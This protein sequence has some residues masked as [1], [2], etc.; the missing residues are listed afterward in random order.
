MEQSSALRESSGA[1]G[2]PPPQEAFPD[3]INPVQKMEHP[4]PKKVFPD[5]LPGTEMMEPV[6]GAECKLFLEPELDLRAAPGPGWIP[7]L[8]MA[9]DPSCFSAKV[10]MPGREQL[11]GRLGPH[12]CSRL[13]L[14]E[15]C[16]GFS[17][18]NPDLCLS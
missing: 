7:S 10:V 18:K 3:K 13:H 4:T 17:L 12:C 16:E 5:C 14:E 9:Q 8:G 11:T 1:A 15:I 2:N 6:D